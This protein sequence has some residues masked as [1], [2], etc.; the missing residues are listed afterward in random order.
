MRIGLGLRVGRSR[1]RI[2]ASRPE[3]VVNGDFASGTLAGWVTASTAPSTVVVTDGVAVCQTDGAASARLRQGVPTAVGVQYRVTATG[4][5]PYAIGSTTG[6]S[7]LLPFLAT[8]SG[9]IRT[10]TATT[11]TTWFNVATNLNGVTLDNVSIKQV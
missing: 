8:P 3:L 1:G 7:D 4:T 6:A 5:A 2:V 11:T 9:D 10:F